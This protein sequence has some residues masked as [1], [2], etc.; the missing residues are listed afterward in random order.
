M[1]V[2]YFVT[3]ANLNTIGLFSAT[4]PTNL[5]N[6][7]GGATTNNDV[8]ASKAVIVNAPSAARIAGANFVRRSVVTVMG[9]LSFVLEGEVH[10]E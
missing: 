7:I 3:V 1:T 9:R 2:T 6:T 8:T 10:A 5:T 4:L